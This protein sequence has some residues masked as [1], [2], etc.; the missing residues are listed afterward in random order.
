[1][2]QH[3]ENNP[4]HIIP[5]QTYLAV[6][7]LL[8]L[9]TIITVWV[10]EYDFGKWNTVIAMIVASV[11]ATFVMLYFMHLKYDNMMNRV[12]F[13]TAFFFLLVLFAFSAVDIYTRIS[14]H[15]SF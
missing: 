12:I 2:S 9:G 10:A 7:G 15:V 6:F 13:G 11:K 8:I 4:H 3:K 1:M 14:Q 5:I